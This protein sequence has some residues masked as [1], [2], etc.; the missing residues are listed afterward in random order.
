MKT[1]I[2]KLKFSS[3]VHFGDGGLTKAHSIKHFVLRP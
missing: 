1:K 2:L 3:N